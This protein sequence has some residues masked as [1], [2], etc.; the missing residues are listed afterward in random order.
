MCCETRWWRWFCYHFV[1]HVSMSTVSIT[2]S[3]DCTRLDINNQWMFHVVSFESQIDV[4]WFLSRFFPNC[5]DKENEKVAKASNYI[6]S[7]DDKEESENLLRASKASTTSSA[8]SLFRLFF[9]S[10]EHC[11]V[12]RRAFLVTLFH[13]RFWFFL[14][15][16]LRRERVHRVYPVT[17]LR[18]VATTYRDAS[19]QWT[20]FY[21]LLV[22]SF[23]MS[24]LRRKT[25]AS[26]RAW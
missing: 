3:C 20:G 10:H 9:R 23:T 2:A 7:S 12:C 16:I 21:S 18:S 8:R 14:L 6:Q 22:A 15:R 17:F 13:S 19:F 1:I 4:W 5:E 26:A 24:S 25:F 11:A